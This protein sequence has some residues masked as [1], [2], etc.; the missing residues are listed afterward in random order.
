[1]KIG[2]GP[3]PSSLPRRGWTCAAPGSREILDFVGLGG[4]GSPGNPAVAPHLLA[5]FP[6]LPGP[7]KPPG[8]PQGREVVSQ[9]ICFS[10]RTPR[11]FERQPAPA[12]A[13]TQDCE[14]CDYASATSTK[15]CDPANASV[16]TPYHSKQ[17]FCKSIVCQREP[18][19]RTIH[20]PAVQQ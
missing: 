13:A 14:S 2:P 11:A 4:P 19:S 17:S 12:P 10:R 15:T 1:M 6:R 18:R 3:L 7:P 16:G 8:P 5:R 20:K 9:T